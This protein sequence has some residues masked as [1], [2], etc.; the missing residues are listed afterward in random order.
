MGRFNAS[1]KGIGDMLT[2]KMMQAAMLKKAEK[3]KLRAEAT[4]PDYKPKGVGYKFE[5][6][7]SSGVKTSK[8]GTRRAYGR[9]TNNSPHARWVEYGGKNTPRHR[10]LGRALDAV[11][12]D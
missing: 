6:E 11:G 9:V 7:V 4:A 3:V 1:Y 8:K 2:S 5:F 12:D 10:T